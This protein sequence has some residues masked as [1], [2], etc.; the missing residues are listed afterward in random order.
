MT[1]IAIAG[2]TYGPEHGADEHVWYRTTLDAEAARKLRR[3]WERIGELDGVHAVE[4]RAH[5]QIES[6]KGP[7]DPETVDMA[8]GEDMAEERAFWLENRA[9]EPDDNRVE[10]ECVKIDSGGGVTW[11]WIPRHASHR[12]LCE[13]DIVGLVELEAALKRKEGDDADQAQTG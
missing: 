3:A 4:L 2:P 10:R 12:C 9:G 6:L 7:P 8:V 13:S 5:G 11:S 1:E